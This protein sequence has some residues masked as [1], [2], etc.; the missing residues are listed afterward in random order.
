M[1]LL[2]PQYCED[3]Y[4]SDIQSIIYVTMLEKVKLVNEC[5][6]EGSQSTKLMDYAR[7]GQLTN[8]IIE[9]FSKEKSWKAADALKL[10]KIKVRD[11]YSEQDSLL[12]EEN[13]ED[14]LL[15]LSVDKIWKKITECLEGL[16]TLH[17]RLTQKYG[18]DNDT[19][20]AWIMEF[21]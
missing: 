5:V 16:K 13:K 4:K 8:Q 11:T 19:A 20:L 1:P 21:K 10:K 3:N 15:N 17:Q 14:S 18:L 9:N 2:W 12:N 6:K 7:I